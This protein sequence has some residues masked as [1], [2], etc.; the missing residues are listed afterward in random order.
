MQ[1]VHGVYKIVNTLV[2][3]IRLKFQGW[4]WG[5]SIE[6]RCRCSYTEDR[7]KCSRDKRGTA[8][9][10]DSDVIVVGS[11][12]C[13]I[14]TGKSDAR[15]GHKDTWHHFRFT[16]PFDTCIYY[17]ERGKVRGDEVSLATSKHQYLKTQVDNGIRSK[18]S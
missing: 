18:H 17:I 5:W 13:L 6:I 16:E 3:E 15:A 10:C 11:S 7:K 9:V 1:K 14:H 8:G 4:W 12:A 2:S